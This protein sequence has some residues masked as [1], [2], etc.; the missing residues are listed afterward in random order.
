VKHDP[1]NI[2]VSSTISRTVNRQFECKKA[3]TTLISLP[4]GDTDG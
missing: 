4:L 2:P 1:M 3:L